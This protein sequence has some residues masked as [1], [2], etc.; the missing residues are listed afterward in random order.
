[1][2]YCRIII[3]FLIANPLIFISQNYVNVEKTLNYDYISWTKDSKKEL[4]CPV[5]GYFDQATFQPVFHLKLTQGEYQIKDFDFEERALTEKEKKTYKNL[6]FD[7]AYSITFR[8]QEQNNKLINQ[9]FLL[10]CIR[11]A[12]DQLY[13]LTD[14]KISLQKLPSSI[15]R[16]KSSSFTNQSVLSD[17][18]SWFKLRNQQPGIYKIDYNFLINNSIIDGSI[19]S[20]NIHLF[21]NNV[22]LL[23]F[24]NNGSRPDDLKQQSIF[25]Y[26]GGD[27]VFSSGDYMLFY[28]NGPDKINW[29]GQNFYHTKHIYSDSAYCFL[30]I[31][32]SKNPELLDSVNNNNQIFD[33]TITKFR[34]FK[35]LNQ[36][37]INLLKSGS[38]WFGDVFDLTNVFT[39][40]FSFNNCIDSSH[41]KLKLMSKSNYSSAYFYP[42]IFNENRSVTIS[43][44]GSSYYADV[45]K[46]AIEEFDVLNN[47]NMPYELRLEYSN[48]GAPSSKG[49]LDYIEINCTRQLTIDNQQFDFH[50]NDI[51]NQ[52][53]WQP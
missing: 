52:K 1:M 43:S 51:G 11:Q 25:I 39:Y 21:S 26:D 27:G 16:T 35:Y 49:Y 33:Q 8:K 46:I 37:K 41:I 19:P 12:A 36:D 17:G 6:L 18:S 5:N 2:K 23:N 13:L 42:S 47:P 31:S 4:L 24:I 40:P 45:G 7:S 48:N 9:L 53:R 22:G 38:Q 32:S 14:F 20:N 34:D 28:L 10:N 50:L 3:F 30:N 44:S 29:D 15:P